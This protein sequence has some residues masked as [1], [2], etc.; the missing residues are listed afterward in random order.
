[1]NSSPGSPLLLL[2]GVYLAV[3]PAHAGIHWLQELG[4]SPW[5]LFPQLLTGDGSDDE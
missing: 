3:I 2:E 5:S 4:D 1:M